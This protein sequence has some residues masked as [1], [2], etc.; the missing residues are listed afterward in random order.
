MT[1]KIELSQSEQMLNNYK[2]KNH[3]LVN[4]FILILKRYIYVIKCQGN[5]I[6]NFSGFLQ[7]VHNT[8]KVEKINAFINDK[9]VIHEKKW[10]P[11]INF[12]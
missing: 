10:S 11:F 6:P 2:G 3:Q 8:Y 1:E 12:I 7:S 5:T 9:T 4:L